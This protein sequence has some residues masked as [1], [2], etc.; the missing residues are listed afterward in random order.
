MEYSEKTANTSFKRF[1]KTL[2]LRNDEELIAKYREIHAAGAAWPE[3]TQGMR[4]VGIVDMEIY[5][6]GNTL[7]MIMETVP[8][9][10]H[11][12]A[13]NRLAGL[14]RQREWEAYVS[15]YQ[16]TS[17]DA[18]SEEKWVLMERIYKLGE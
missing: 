6:Q 16:E 7:F 1:C 10:D 8:D 18:G 3:I 14:P 15:Q 12:A 17:S 9:F 13:M 11:D 5:L 2:K 4:E